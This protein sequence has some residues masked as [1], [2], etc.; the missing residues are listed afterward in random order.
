MIDFEQIA[1]VGV[2]LIG[3]SIGID[4]RMRKLTRKVVGIGRRASSLRTARKLGA[5]DSTTLD[6]ARGVRNADLVIL[7]TSAAAIAPLGARAL[8]SMKPGA[9]LT[10]VGSTK[11][12][13]SKNIANIIKTN[14]YKDLTYIGSHPLAGSHER[15]AAAAREGLFENAVCVLA[16]SANSTKSH[17]G[18]LTRFWRS[19]GMKIVR[20]E[21]ARH[22]T[23]LAQVSHLPHAIS[24]ALMNATEDEALALAAGGFLDT[25]RI[26][27]SEGRLWA[28]I[29]LTN[30]SM[31]LKS[32]KRFKLSLSEIEKAIKN[33]DADTLSKLL[34]DACVRRKKMGHRK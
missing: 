33:N 3:G 20:M 19:L 2:G 11:T 15:G 14:N 32:I 25:T 9:L 16:G 17:Q 8:A 10:D 23:L 7:A 31:M 34:E 13:I 26:A 12:E 1:I 29:F 4:V 22:D 27:S 30:S 6:I 18:R 24:F 28:D 21:P 5:V